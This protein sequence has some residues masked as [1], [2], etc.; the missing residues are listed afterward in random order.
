MK[1][2]QLNRTEFEAWLSQQDTL[3]AGRCPLE[4]YLGPDIKVAV[5]H[6]ATPS[7]SKLKLP[8]WVQKF[9]EDVDCAIEWNTED[10]A[11]KDV[12]AILND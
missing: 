11:A 3:C 10:Y 8:V 1:Q 6:A 2:L 9:T 4:H 7:G 5:E 12:L